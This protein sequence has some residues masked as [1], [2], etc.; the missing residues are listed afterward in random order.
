MTPELAVRLM[1]ITFSS[2]LTAAQHGRA[3]L[4]NSEKHDKSEYGQCNE[5][6]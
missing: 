2:R 4:R 1:G 6:A 3:E 5:F